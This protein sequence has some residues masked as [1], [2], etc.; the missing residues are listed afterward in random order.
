[1]TDQLSPDIKHT[2]KRTQKKLLHGVACVGLIV[3]GGAVCLYL[4]DQAA[5]KISLWLY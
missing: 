1:M 2:R 3:T 5:L 4:L